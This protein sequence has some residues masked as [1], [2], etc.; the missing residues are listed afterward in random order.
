MSDLMPCQMCQFYGQEDETRYGEDDCG[1]DEVYCYSC[2]VRGP[3]R[4]NGDYAYHMFLK[5]KDCGEKRRKELLAKL[6]NEMQAT[7]ARGLLIDSCETKKSRS[8]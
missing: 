6:W 4:V 7:I 5:D 2:G 3:N 1:N 8:L